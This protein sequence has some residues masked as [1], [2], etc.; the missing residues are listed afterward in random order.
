MKIN[1]RESGRGI[2]LNFS[3]KELIQQQLY[4]KKNINEMIIKGNDNEHKRNNTNV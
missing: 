3:I 1:K 4:N 2:L